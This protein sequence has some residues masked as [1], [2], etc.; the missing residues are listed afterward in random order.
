MRNTNSHCECCTPLGIQSFTADS[1]I[2]PYTQIWFMLPVGSAMPTIPWSLVLMISLWMMHRIDIE[3]THGL[4]WFCTLQWIHCTLVCLSTLPGC[5]QMRS[6]EWVYRISSTAPSTLTSALGMIW[7]PSQST[8]MMSHST[9]A[10]GNSASTLLLVPQRCSH[11]R[12][13]ITMHH[14]KQTIIQS[15]SRGVYI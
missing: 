14:M 5:L 6:L 2:P 1:R 9:H 8:H 12:R 15:L 11:W 3:S 7:V 10:P 13:G 4:G